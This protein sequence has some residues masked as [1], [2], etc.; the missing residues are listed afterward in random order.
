MMVLGSCK[1]PCGKSGEKEAKQPMDINVT[2]F[3]KT[4]EGQEVKLYTLRNANGADGGHHDLRGDRRVAE[5]AGRQGPDGRYRA[6][7]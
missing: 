7:V 4:P 3:G 1:C 2:T 6:G 5:G